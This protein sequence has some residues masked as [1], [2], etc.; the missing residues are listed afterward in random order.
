LQRSCRSLYP[1]N[2]AC[3]RA[4]G[5][6]PKVWEL[7]TVAAVWKGTSRSSGLE[8]FVLFADARWAL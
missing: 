2:V 7:Q 8:V 6:D 5:D 1:A 3:P 4:D